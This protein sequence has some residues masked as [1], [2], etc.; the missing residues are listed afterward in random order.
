MYKDSSI[1]YEKNILKSYTSVVFIGLVSL[2][3]LPFVCKFVNVS[4]RNLLTSCHSRFWFTQQISHDSIQILWLLRPRYV[5]YLQET[6]WR[7]WLLRTTW[8]NLTSVTSQYY[9]V[10]LITSQHMFAYLMLRPGSVHIKRYG[11]TS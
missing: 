4:W 9:D 7:Y 11:K 5:N 10:H 1:Y 2:G 6:N 8:F 3:H